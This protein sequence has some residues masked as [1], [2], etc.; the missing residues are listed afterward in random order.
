MSGSL[1]SAV[2]TRVDVVASSIDRDTAGARPPQPDIADVAMT[3]GSRNDARRRRIR[4]LKVYRPSLYAK[5]K[6]PRYIPVA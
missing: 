2:F 4:M 5:A 6:A 3:R 1:S